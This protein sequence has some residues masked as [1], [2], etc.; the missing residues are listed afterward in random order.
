MRVGLTRV[1][2]WEREVEIKRERERLREETER[3]KEEED[4]DEAMKSVVTQDKKTK[5]KWPSSNN[6]VDHSNLIKPLWEHGSS[7]HSR[8]AAFS[9]KYFQFISN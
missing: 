8:R 1:S 6:R 4:E 2:T 5:G 9:F 7:Q 3:E